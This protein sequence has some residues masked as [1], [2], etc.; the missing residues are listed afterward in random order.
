MHHKILVTVEKDD[1]LDTSETAR[2]YV[3]EYLAEQRFADGGDNPRFV[4]HVGYGDYFCIGGRW[5]GL[6]TDH[7]YKLRE[8]YGQADPG[9]RS[10]ELL[11]ER[12]FFGHEDDAQV[13]TKELY[14]RFLRQWEE[15]AEGVDPGR[16]DI[17]DGFFVREHDDG[18]GYDGFLDIEDEAVDADFIGRKWLVVVD[19]HE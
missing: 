5:S 6:L 3:A 2:R 16:E 1:E 17:E 4:A 11:A 7:K 12:T 9:A 13:V 15:E 18:Y 19:L 10:S 8:L 14:D